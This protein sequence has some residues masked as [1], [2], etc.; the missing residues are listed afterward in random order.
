MVINNPLV[1][2]L[3]VT[4]NSG[5]YIIDTLESIKLQ[6]YENIELIISDDGSLDK[7]I[8]LASD[9][10]SINKDRFIRTQII[11]VEKNTGVSANYN[12]GV[13]ECTGSW[14]KNVDGDDLITPNCIESNLRYIEKHSD[15][16]VLFSDMIVFRGSEDNVLYKYSDTDFKGFFELPANDQFKRLIIRNQLPSATLFI[17]ADVLK[18]YPY[19]EVYKGVEDYPMWVTLTRNGHKIFYMDEIT[20]K[21]RKGDSLTSSSQR[22]FSTYYMDSMEQFYWREL[23]YF[24]KENNCEEGILYHMKHFMLY[25]IAIVVFN[26]K[27][28]FFY[29]ALFSILRRILKCE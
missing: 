26:N 18:K 21:Y 13:A 20:A 14:I 12:R 1:S 28:L 11:A 5:D 29:R 22:L 25:H 17:K 6:T 19:N 8:Q 27:G 24:L 23:Y 10:I 16:E 3:V 15:I 2:I 7:T 4:Y 9:W